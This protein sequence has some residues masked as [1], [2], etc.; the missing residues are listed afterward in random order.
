MERCTIRELETSSSRFY[1]LF[2]L[3]FFFFFSFP[4]HR[5]LHVPSKSIDI[6]T[7]LSP[8]VASVRLPR[9]RTPGTC[10]SSLPSPFLFALYS[11]FQKGP[12]CPF[13]DGKT[14][15]QF[16]VA[17]ARTS[18]N[19]LGN[20]RVWSN[21]METSDSDMESAVS[22]YDRVPNRFTRTS[23]APR[24]D[25]FF[26]RKYASRIPRSFFPSLPSCPSRVPS[27]VFHSVDFVPYRSEIKDTT[28]HRSSLLTN[29]HWCQL[30][31]ALEISLE[32]SDRER[33]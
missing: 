33:S 13:A 22:F 11:I 3:F 9:C 15:F 23:I 29:C 24:D 20:V 19:N 12:L 8:Y 6:P 17:A 2:F 5:P 7:F 16:S 1:V 30:N 32:T 18:W 21:N 28:L 10:A 26:S 25:G 14:L 27:R 4:L 31:V